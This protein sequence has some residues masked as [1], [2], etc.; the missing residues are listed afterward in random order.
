MYVSMTRMLEK[1]NKEN[2][3]V[4]IRTLNFERQ[5]FKDDLL[6]V[7]KKAYDFLE[8]SSVIPNDILMNKI[9][10]AGDS[11]ERIRN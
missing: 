5:D 6:Y 9:A 8:K 2:Y 11:Y 4:M 7:T 10:N 3:A 1:A